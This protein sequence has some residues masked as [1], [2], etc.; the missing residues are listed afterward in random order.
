MALK[1][2]IAGTAREVAV[3]V[4]PSWVSGWV[5]FFISV[6]TVG[7][8]ILLTRFGTTAQ[9]SLLGLHS[10][11]GRSSIA[12]SATSIEQQLDGN[13]LFNDA[14]LF[15]LWGS[16]GLVVYSVVQGLIKELQNTDDLLHEIH[17]VHADR[18]NLISGTIL[19]GIIRLAGLA[20]WWVLAWAMLHKIFPYAIASAHLS[21]DHLA[22]SNDWIHA[23]LGFCYCLLSIQGLTVCARLIV[24]RPRLTGNAILDN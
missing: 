13:T 2:G 1:T 3:L 8:T 14:V 7:G 20:A 21:A 6:I 22:S 11:Y 24:L 17:Y 15:I 18:Q 12:G 19:R 9:Q 16:V 4:M 10:V 23:L 5:A